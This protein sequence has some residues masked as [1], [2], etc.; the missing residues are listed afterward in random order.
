MD[1]PRLQAQLSV[2]RQAEELNDYM[3]DL[4]GWQKEL[5][6][7]EKSLK[8]TAGAELPPVRGKAQPLAAGPATSPAGTGQASHAS[9]T[10][11]VAGAPRHPAAHTYDNYRSKWDTFDV[12]AAL[13]GSDVEEVASQ[14]PGSQSLPLASGNSSST[15]RGDGGSH[16]TSARSTSDG[17][18]ISGSGAAAM[19]AGSDAT[20][21]AGAPLPAARI[22]AAAQAAASRPVQPTTAEQWKDEG[23]RSF[24][25]GA[26]QKASKLDVCV[27]EPLSARG[28]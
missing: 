22:R 10:E 16:S 12:D 3:K 21:K 5:K 28:L 9:T 25:A 23:N 2:R 11:P 14:A 17:G 4:F 27:A 1:D 18:G 19:H 15:T 8:R 26:Y 6:Q 24:K 13:A 20:T 7:K